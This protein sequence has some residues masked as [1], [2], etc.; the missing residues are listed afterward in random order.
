MNAFARYEYAMLDSA[1]LAFGRD[2]KLQLGVRDIPGL[3]RGELVIE[4]AG[5]VPAASLRLSCNHRYPIY[6]TQFAN[7]MNFNW[8][9]E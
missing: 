5:L 6:Y 3:R 7:L 4:I 1:H 8:F 2:V 9:V